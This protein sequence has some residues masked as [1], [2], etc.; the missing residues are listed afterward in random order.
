[1]VRLGKTGPISRERGVLIA[2]TVLSSILV[3]TLTPLKNRFTADTVLRNERIST[4][5]VTWEIIKDY[6]VFGIGFGMQTYD[7][8]DF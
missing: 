2:T 4:N 3:I 7:N 6:P 5:L 1:L 8:T